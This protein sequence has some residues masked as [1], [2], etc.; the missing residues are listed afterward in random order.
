MVR[1]CTCA[2]ASAAAR[3]AAASARVGA[4][5]ITLASIGSYDVPTGV[6]STTP[7]SSRMPGRPGTSN[8]ASTPGTANRRTV[9]PVGRQ[10]CAG[11]S[12]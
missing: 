1:P 9:P 10:P 8:S 11:S 12:A 4:Q 5:A 2:P 7:A 6:P 3:R